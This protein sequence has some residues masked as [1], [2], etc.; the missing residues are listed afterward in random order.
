MPLYEYKCERCAV[1]IEKLQ[2]M[3]KMGAL[4]PECGHGMRRVYSPLAYIHMKGT[5]YPARRKW[6]DDW[7]PDSPAFSTGSLHGE[8]Y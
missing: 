2:Q 7:T 8:R 4:C 6:M 3:D 1:N 5:G